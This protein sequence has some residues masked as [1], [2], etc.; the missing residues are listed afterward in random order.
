MSSSTRQFLMIGLLVIGVWAAVAVTQPTAST[1]SSTPLST[2][3]AKRSY[4][5]GHAIG[6]FARERL[7]EDAVS[8]DLD[9]LVE[10]FADAVHDRTPDFDSDEMQDVLRIVERQVASRL[11]ERRMDEDPVFRALAEENLKRS[12]AFHERFGEEEGV[13]TLPSGVQYRVVSAGE[14]DSPTASDTVSVSFT[15]SLI[16]GSVVAVAAKEST[17]VAGMIE[18][19][20]EIITHMRPGAVW[21]VA[22]PPHLAFGLGG[23]E[24]L[25]GPNETLIV[26]VQLV[27][28]Q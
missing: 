21:Q 6:N 4:A 8:V 11:A 7:N 23:Q 17:R 13:T 18:G 26:D 16:D 14:G 28:I 2:D 19:G 12:R 27:E 1:P 9:L 22:I 3:E 10:G 20:R 15:A 25:I 5:V 24:P